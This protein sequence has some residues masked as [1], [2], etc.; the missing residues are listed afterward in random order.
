[1]IQQNSNNMAI[2]ASRAV[3]G[4]LSAAG[5]R[6]LGKLGI[7]AAMAL[8]ANSAMAERVL[9]SIDHSSTPGG[10]VEIVLSMSGSG[11]EATA[12][13]TDEPPRIALD[14]A[15]TFN[16]AGRDRINVGAGPVR[17][18]T[19]VEA[20][21]RTRVVVELT[22]T[23]SFT[24]DDQ[25]DRIVLAVRQQRTGPATQEER[26]MGRRAEARVT[27]VDF[28]RGSAGEGRVVL[29]LSRREV[30]FD[31]EVIGREIRLRLYNA[32]VDEQHIRKLDVTD[33]ATPVSF[34]NTYPS[35]DDALVVVQTDQPFEQLVYQTE[36]S[37]VLEVA[38][39]AD[40]DLDT[41][42]TIADRTYSGDPV[43]FN[44]QDIP[45]RA[46]L[47]FLADESDLNIV[48]SDSVS[49]S[50][51][52]RLINVPWD[53][54]LDIILDARGLDKRR[55]GNVL[56]VGPAR[57]IAERERQAFEVLQSQQRL[58]PLQTAFIQ[59]NYAGAAR[60][61]ELLRAAG[62][63]EDGV[64][65]SRGS[66]NVDDRTNTLLV[67]DTADRIQRVESM[68][69]RLDRP[70]KQ[71]L[72]ESRIVTANDDYSRELG[73]RFGV[74]SSRL[75]DSGNLISTS[76]S[77][78][79]LDRMNNQALI[80]RLGGGLGTPSV[81]PGGPGDGIAGPPLN[82]RLNVSL[83]TSS[84]PAGRFGLSILGS[85]FL[86]DLELSALEQERRGEVI[87]SPRVITA[88]QSEAFIRQGREIPFLEAAASGAATVSF[89]RAELE[90]RV[91]PLITPDN[92][93]LMQLSVK[94]DTQGED[95]NVAT[96]GT[97]PAIDTRQI[98]TEV[99]VNNGETVVLGGIYEQRID[100]RRTRVP[101]LGD[102]PGVGALFRST[103]R[104]DA[105]AELLIFITPRILQESLGR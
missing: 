10:D 57:E 97:A 74:T 3:A 41:G 11:P 18:V 20:G 66:V 4:N 15:E 14:L 73:A 90:L 36:D 64:L 43:T 16:D 44:F 33:F 28:R 2:R 78:A 35:G 39:P 7:L 56:L 17:G 104:E 13:A 75:S 8:V 83:P 84:D 79:A 24:V 42:L 89:K 76:G 29:D 9:E 22:S 47:Q 37:L 53:Q 38:V 25:G 81:T 61:A 19:A 99:L 77:S 51:T 49:G 80:N 69:A 65:S 88:N 72:I 12:F 92:R 54:A 91:V 67:T 46:V 30:G 6:L 5:N 52:L 59:V 23:S 100:E 62:G 98:E 58:A 32:S 105:K 86:V 26:A 55:N 93:I 40:E 34:I 96:G 1:M 95:V 27:G 21:G 85:N 94:Q 103:E 48:V 71:V 101:L 68:V 50:M 60:M 70:V 102:I 31:S 82:E 45:V 63:D 87:S